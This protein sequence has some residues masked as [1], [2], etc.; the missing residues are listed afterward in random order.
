MAYLLLVGDYK[1]KSLRE[2]KMVNSSKFIE[3]TCDEYV[4]R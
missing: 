3:D 4:T 1:I 2:R